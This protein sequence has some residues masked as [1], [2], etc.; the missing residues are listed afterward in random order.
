MNKRLYS[1]RDK[2]AGTF[3]MPYPSHNDDTAIRDFANTVKNSEYPPATHPED[4][5]LYYVGTFNDATGEVFNTENGIFK[6]T[7]AI[8]LVEKEQ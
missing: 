7:E 2:L 4:F 1:I 6:L 3:T 8:A 5:Q